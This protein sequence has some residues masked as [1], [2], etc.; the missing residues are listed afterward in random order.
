MPIYTGILVLDLLF[1]LQ[2]VNTSK[3][4]INHNLLEDDNGIFFV[5]NKLQ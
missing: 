2:L 5:S 3:I 4:S 1:L